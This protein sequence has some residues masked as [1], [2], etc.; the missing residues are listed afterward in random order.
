MTM[1]HENA[2]LAAACGDTFVTGSAE[3]RIPLT[4]PLN[5]GK[6]G[7]SIFMDAGAA[8]AKGQRFTDQPL[9]KGIGGGVWISA[10]VFRMSLSV[11]HGLVSGTR[12]NF[13]A[14]LTF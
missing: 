9:N 11:A 5:V 4:S 2:A 14:G 6:L 8:Y 7:V 13:G 1:T 3:L 10:A 12:V